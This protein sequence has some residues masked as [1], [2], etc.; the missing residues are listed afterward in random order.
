[1][2]K[3]VLTVGEA[4]EL[5]NVATSTIYDLRN[6]GVLPQIKK[7]SGVRFRAKD[8]YALAGVTDVANTYTPANFEGLQRELAAKEKQ[9]QKIK[10]ASLAL[11]AAI[12]GEGMV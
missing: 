6:R 11:L 5:L 7:L 3:L 9:L 12:S 4:A 2:D 10:T 8:V 1:M